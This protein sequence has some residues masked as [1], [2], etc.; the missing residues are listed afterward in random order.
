V[1]VRKSPNILSTSLPV[2]AEQ[3]NTCFL[4]ELKKLAKERS[5]DPLQLALG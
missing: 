2:L 3:Q 5:L 4:L 1:K